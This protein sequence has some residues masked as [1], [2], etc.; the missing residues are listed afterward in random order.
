VLHSKSVAGIIKEL[1]VFALVYNLVRVVMLEAGHRQG[2]SAERI[3][4]AD[5]L[6]WL[7]QAQSGTPLRPQAVNPHRAGRIEPRVCKRRPKSYRL[8]T[9]PRAK[10]RKALRS[11]KRAA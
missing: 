4:F 6:R 5:A 9:Q 3:S 11:K 8:L 7:R 2:V 1:S 10:L